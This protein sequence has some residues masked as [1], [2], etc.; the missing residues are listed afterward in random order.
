MPY[1]EVLEVVGLDVPQDKPADELSEG[2]RHRLC[3]AR[4]LLLRPQVLMLDEP[5][6][7]L[8]V[9]TAREMLT[10]LVAWTRENGVTLVC[11]THRPE[12]LE[13]L[14]GEALILLK[15]RVAGR[16]PAADVAARKV[17]ADTSA[18]LGKQSGVTS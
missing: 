15:G 12:D 9:R 11:V 5:T 17:D 10:A 7:A 2:Q 16:Y 14:G 3:I 4:A 18:F 13:L 1:G 6:G 8:D